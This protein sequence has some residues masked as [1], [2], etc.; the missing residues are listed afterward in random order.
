[1]NSLDMVRENCRTADS[2]GTG[3]FTQAVFDALK[4]V[5][6]AIRASDKVGCTGCRYCM[7]CPKG[8]DIPGTFR[9]YNAMFIESPSEGRMQ[10]AQT[11]GLTREPAFASQCVRCGKCEKHCPQGIP[12]REKLKEA[13][14]ALRPLPYKIG[15]NIVRRFMFRKTKRKNKP[16]RRTI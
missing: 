16:E 12:I 2:A 11:V 3:T 15:I 13:D 8:V 5:T 1:M 10:F 9:C 14:K 4:R 6:G 7:P